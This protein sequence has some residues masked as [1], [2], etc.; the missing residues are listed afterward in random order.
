MKFLFFSSVK[1]D[2]ILL[3]I[4]LLV[5]ISG[6]QKSYLDPENPFLSDSDSYADP[7]A[8][9]GAKANNY[10]VI[11]RSETLPAGFEFQL[12]TYGQIVRTIP[13]IG[14]VVVKPVVPDFKAKVS[15]LAQVQGVVPDFNAQWIKPPKY[16]IEANPPSIGDYEPGF[17][18]QWGMDAINAPEAWNAGYE[19]ENARIFVLD[20]G[21]DDDHPDLVA[22]LNLALSAS[23]VPDESSFDDGYGHG[24]HVAGIIAAA[25]NGWG[26][27]GV[28]PKAEIVAAK[29]LSSSGSGDFSWVNSGII[30]AADH[31]ADVINMSLG[32]TLK[33]SGFYEGSEWISPVDVT[34]YVLAQQRAVDYASKK[35]AVIVTSA[36]NDSYNLDGSASWFVLPGGLQKVITVSATAPQCWIL[37]WNNNPFL[38]IPASYTNYGRSLIE[39]AAP[40][41]DYDCNYPDPVM[42]YPARAFDYVISTY[43]GGG[44]AWASGTSMAAPHVAGVAALIIGKKGGQMNPIDV[45]RKLLTTAD[46]IDGKGVTPYYGYGRVNA[47][48]AVTE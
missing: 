12:A 33:R 19:G 39:L 24:T 29:V 47:Y 9:K 3:A 35:G 32:T 10:M 23:F 25:H 14:V 27:I 20:T 5:F 4:F 7:V 38:D 18:L 42:G 37:E 11:T 40:G 41:G 22:N 13:Q 16:V 2:R 21:I 45:T 30:Y 34:Y 46:K 31:G 6:C 15:K 48:R 43:R 36:G 17:W 1:F 28:A 8:L 26:V 44:F